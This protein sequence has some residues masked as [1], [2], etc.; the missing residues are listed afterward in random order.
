MKVIVLILIAISSFG[1]MS[2]HRDEYGRFLP[3]RPNWKLSNQDL[4]RSEQIDYN[5][6]YVGESPTDRNATYMLITFWPEGHFM[7]RHSNSSDPTQMDSKEESAVGYFYT[8]GN[9]LITEN[10]ATINFG[11]YGYSVFEILSDG[12]LIRISHGHSIRNQNKIPK[13][14]RPQLQPI[15]HPKTFSPDW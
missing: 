11:Q 15:P 3:N 2:G 7:R 6:V 1:C 13:Q 5:S 10:Y 9:R 8:D 12:S 14:N 4:N